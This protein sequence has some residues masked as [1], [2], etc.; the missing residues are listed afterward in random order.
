M[1]NCSKCNAINDDE[2][3]FCSQCGT[4]F[5]Q[6]DNADN[7]EETVVEQIEKEDTAVESAQAET[8]KST[9][10]SE[11]ASDKP[12]IVQTSEKSDEKPETPID[13]NGVTEAEF[14]AFVGRNQN[15]FVPGFRRFCLGKK[16]IFS[17]LVFLLTW[18]VSPFAGAFWFFHR[19]MNKIGAVALAIA[20]ALTLV[21]GVTAFYMTEDVM[22]ITAEYADTQYKGVGNTFGSYYD[23]DESDID[24]YLDRYFGYDDNNGYGNYYNF[25]ESIAEYY[26]QRII[27]SVVKYLPILLIVSVLNFVFALILG[28]FAK[29]LY[30]KT[31][32]E[33]I[34]EIKQNNPTPTYINDVAVAGGTKAIVWVICLIALIAV[35]FISFI[36][37]A[38]HLFMSVYSNGYIDF[39]VR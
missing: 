13:L 9:L 3:K 25:D 36:F 20:A 37:I 21:S 12:P 19:K 29:Y 22:K 8:E 34:L 38:F 16:A 6:A 26:A 24:D 27:Q 32:V 23:Y 28:I 39:N 33:K 4:A 7:T 30:Y 11:E 15:D 1:K 17:P 2:A 18:L 10:K 31:A 5:E 14:S 35:I